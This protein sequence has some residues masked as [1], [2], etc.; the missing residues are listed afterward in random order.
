M[1]AATEM[2]GA[3]LPPRT[4]LAGAMASGYRAAR[5]DN[6]EQ[7]TCFAGCRALLKQGGQVGRS[8]LVARLADLSDVRMLHIFG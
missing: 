6:R 7:A 2:A 1:A 5:A 3:T 8:S 4:P